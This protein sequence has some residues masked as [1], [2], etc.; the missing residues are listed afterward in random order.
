VLTNIPDA[1]IERYL[2]TLAQRI[3]ATAPPL[4]GI[5]LLGS[6]ALGDFVRGRSDLDVAVVRNHPLD[7]GTKRRLASTVSHRLLPCPA[8]RLELVVYRAARLRAP[9]VDPA[10]ELNLNTGAGERDHVSMDPG[11]EEPHWFILDIGMAR[12]HA[13]PLMGPPPGE[14]F[15]AVPRE[16][17]L[18]AMITSIHWH[19]SH[20][21]EGV[22]TVFSAC[23]AW[24][25]AEEGLWSSKG[26]AAQWASHRWNERGVIDQAI[27]ARYNGEEVRLPR[28][29]VRSLAAAV[30]TSLT[31]AL[32]TRRFSPEAGVRSRP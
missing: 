7:T 16:R 17:I 29:A 9:V 4:V 32:G 20:D 26:A 8:R 23:R 13:R 18:A 3:N 21:L 30:G 2:A 12:E 28:G 25:F 15:G 1:N 19:A 5:Y 24:R 11:D 31:D 10:F 6:A 27:A 22:E 14:V